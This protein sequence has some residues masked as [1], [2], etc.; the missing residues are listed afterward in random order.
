VIRKDQNISILVSEQYAR[1]V[2]PI[3]DYA[4]ILENGAAVLEGTRIELM[5]NPDVR[6]AYFG[7]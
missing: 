6:S 1:P 4:F 3:V 5:N 2:M 7:V